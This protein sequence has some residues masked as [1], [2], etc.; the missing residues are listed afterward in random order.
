MPDSVITVH[1]VVTAIVNHGD[2]PETCTVTYTLSNV[3]TSL[4]QTRNDIFF[5]SDLTIN[6]QTSTMDTATKQAQI[7]S[8]FLLVA[9]YYFNEFAQYVQAYQA[10]QDLASLIGSNDSTVVPENQN[11]ENPTNVPYVQYP[12][13]VASSPEYDFPIFEGDFFTPI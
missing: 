13:A 9:G 1:Y 6:V 5:V 3:A 7:Q 4:T 12:P 10:D 8:N 2:A 11:P